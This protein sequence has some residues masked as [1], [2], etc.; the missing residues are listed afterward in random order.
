MATVT[1]KQPSF[2]APERL[3]SHRGMIAA[4][5]I[6]QTRIR[7]AA[8]RGIHCDRMFVGRRVFYRGHSVI[9]F[10]ER[11]AQDEIQKALEENHAEVAQ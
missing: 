1:A 3:Y 10:I 2:I 6:S 8:G 11:L 5:G 4:T 7:Q 9:A